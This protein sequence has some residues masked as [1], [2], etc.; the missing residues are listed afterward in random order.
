MPEERF[1]V[2]VV[3]VRRKLRSAWASHAWAPHAVLPAAPAAAP[4]TLLA[5]EGDDET[6]YAGPADLVFHSGETAHYRDNLA[7]ERPS[8]WVALR[9]T[10]GE[11]HEIAGVTADPYEGEAFAES[12][13]LLVEPV[14]MPPEFAERLAAFF[15][16]HHVERAFF[17][18]KR[19]RAGEGGPRGPRPVD[20]GEG[21]P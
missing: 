20:A 10:A 5:R 3:A 16:A 17:K 13:D 14:P 9:P 8:L 7:S 19:D 6:W 1:T 4:W 21:E 15:A 18:R 11:E 2:G 12:P